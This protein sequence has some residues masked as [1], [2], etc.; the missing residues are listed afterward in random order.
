MKKMLV[1]VA[2]LAMYA[3]VRAQSVQPVQILEY[4]GSDQKTPVKGVS[5]TVG[6]AGAA[7]SDEQGMLTLNFRTLKPG[8]PVQIRRI[9]KAGYEVFNIEAVEQWIIA[10]KETFQLVIC[11]SERIKALCDL[12]N[13][14]ASENYSKQLQQEK[15]RLEADRKAG[16]LKED[17]Y[18]TE[19]QKTE[20]L[21]AQQLENLDLYVEK[22]A[23]I[24]L[25]ELNDQEKEIIGLVQKGLMDEAIIKY[26]QMDLLGKYREQ[27]KSIK[28]IRTAQDSLSVIYQEKAT[29]RDSLKST[30]DMM[31]KVKK[32]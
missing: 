30:I 24:D 31:E 2:L 9:D 7:L 4:N 19:L 26:E 10:P 28:Q 29:A 17:E 5:L 20:D 21:Y 27:S 18:K 8:D 22:F 11:K 25:S 23:H 14:A 12:Y 1:W 3:T 16:R 15:D 6:N 32:Q 13:Q